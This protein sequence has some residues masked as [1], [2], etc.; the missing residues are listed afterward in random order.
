MLRL[1]VLVFAVLVFGAQ[2]VFA[3]DTALAKSAI[4]N[5]QSICYATKAEFS[6]IKKLIKPLGFMQMPQQYAQAAVGPNA[7]E[8]ELYV[9]EKHERPKIILLSIGK[10]NMCSISIQ[11][12]DFSKTKELAIKEFS[13]KHLFTKDLSVATHELYVPNGKF[14]SMEEVEASGVID[15]IYSDM[16]GQISYMPPNTATAMLK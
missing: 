15:L 2:L 14:G 6:E 5:F 11:G 16:R 10:P 9:V 3:D 8:A 13:L 4:K 7:T 12:V 1:S